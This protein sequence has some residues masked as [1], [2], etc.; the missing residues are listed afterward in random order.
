MWPR[1]K[2]GTGNG[3]WQYSYNKMWQF[4]TENVMPI[5]IRPTLRIP[6]RSDRKLPWESHNFWINSKIK[7]ICSSIFLEQNHNSS[8]ALFYWKLLTEMS[9]ISSWWDIF[10]Y[11]THPRCYCPPHHP[12]FPIAY[13]AHRRRV[14]E[15]KKGGGG[16]EEKARKF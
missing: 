6:R 13:V 1:E 16:G 9:K 2:R 15:A 5:S 7:Y 3:W 12:T 4:R 8:S 14:R 10:L 11:V